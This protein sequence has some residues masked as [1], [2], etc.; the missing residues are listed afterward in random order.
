MVAPL[1]A[2]TVR[3]A[4]LAL[5]DTLDSTGALTRPEQLDR[6]LSEERIRDVIHVGDRVLLPHMRT[7]AVAELVVALGVTPKPLATDGDAARGAEQVVV[8]VLAPPA[9]AQLYLQVIAALA[10]ALRHDEVVDALIRSESVDD[11][12]G[13]AEIASLVIQPRLAVRDVMTQR[14]YR[15][16]P[17]TPLREAMELMARHNLKS[18]P[19]VGEKREVLGMI[20]ERDLLRHLLPNVVRADA[21]EEGA[22]APRA[23]PG[24]L[25]VR[26][27]M[28]RSVMCVSEDQALADVAATMVNKDAERLPVVSEGRL[29]GFLTRSDILRKLFS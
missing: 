10:R 22:S 1:Q 9:A 14:V 13:L 24:D 5:L 19:V 2:D 11:V 29:T 27:V 3:E 28:S 21:G 7:D 26:D 25:P 8:L 18:V 16:T 4:V 15:V 23:R 12:L 6:L 17:D 20:S